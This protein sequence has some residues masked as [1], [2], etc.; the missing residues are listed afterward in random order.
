MVEQAKNVIN[1]DFD[2][3]EI[4]NSIEKAIDEN[5]KKSIKKNCINPYGMVNLL[6]KF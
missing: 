4:K 6:K 2:K 3:S 1:C 5:F